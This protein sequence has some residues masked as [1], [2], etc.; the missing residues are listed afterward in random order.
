LLDAENLKSLLDLAAEDAVA[1][2]DEKTGRGI[3]GKGLDDLPG[4]PLGSWV[5]GDIDM[6]DF[7]AIQ[8]RTSMGYLRSSRLSPIRGAK[9][10][11]SELPP[12]F[13]RGK[14][15]LPRRRVTR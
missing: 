4:R 10:L 12:S 9:F 7:P 15:T 1:V 14:A 6:Y 13:R 8:R 3:E 5:I 11:K 2:P